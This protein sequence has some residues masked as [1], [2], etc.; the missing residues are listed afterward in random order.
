MDATSWEGASEY[1][2]ELA[3]RI[4]ESGC[5]VALLIGDSMGASGALLC[6]SASTRIARVVAFT[7]QT[8]IA[9]YAAC[10]RDD[11]TANARKRF[12]E[13]LLTAARESHASSIRVHYGR[14]CEEDVRQVAPLD[15]LAKHIHLTAHDFDDHTLSIH[16]RER[17]ELGPIVASEIAAT[18][19]LATS[20]KGTN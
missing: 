11:F 7:P 20:Q 2:S 6:A 13:A 17:G 15:G 8:D 1:A 3:R 5:T 19:A 12:H 18:L 4:D 10:Q 16:L 14:H 9:A